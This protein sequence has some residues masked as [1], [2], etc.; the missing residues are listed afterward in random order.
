MIAFVAHPIAAAQTL[1]SGEDID[2]ENVFASVVLKTRRPVD[3]VHAPP[4]PQ[5]WVT[6][7]GESSI[8]FGIRFWHQPDI[9]TLFRV[10]SAVAMAVKA[11]FD[12]E[13]IENPFPQ[14]VVTMVEPSGDG[15]GPGRSVEQRRG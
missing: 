5:A 7:F 8:D 9:A 1:P 3:G 15:R 11:A 2:L 13:G 10:R 14:R 6:T 12:A 4:L